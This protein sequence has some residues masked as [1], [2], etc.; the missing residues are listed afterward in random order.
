MIF[1]YAKMPHLDELVQRIQ[2]LE[3][4][5]TEDELRPPGNTDEYF[6]R[7]KGTLLRYS[8]AKDLKTAILEWD[9]LEGRDWLVYSPGS[10]CEL[11]GK[12]PISWLF[13]I[14]NKVTKKTLILGKECIRNFTHIRVQRYTGPMD[15]I[16]RRQIRDLERGKN[17]SMEPV[18][19]I[20]ALHEAISDLV[21][22]ATGQGDFDVNKHKLAL[23]DA[24]LVAV[25]LGVR[26]QNFKF[27]DK[28]LQAAVQIQGFVS[29]TVKINVHQHTM[30]VSHLAAGIATRPK[31]SLQVKIEQL[32]T[33]RSLLGQL[34]QGQS[35]H[36]TLVSIWKDIAD[37]AGDQAKVVSEQCDE[38][39]TALSKRYAPY[40]EML[41]SYQYL[42]FVLTNGLNRCRFEY[43]QKAKSY[44]AK[45]TSQGYLDSL[46]REIPG[47]LDSVVGVELFNPRILQDNPHPQVRA[48][49]H[50]VEFLDAVQ[51]GAWQKSIGT[52]ESVFK[53]Q[54]TDRVGVKAALLHCA[55]DSLIFPDDSGI[56]AIEDF[57]DAITMKSP[58][59]VEVVQQEVDDL[60]KT[61]FEGLRVHEKMSE[62]LGF[63]VR[64]TFQAF[65]ARVP[66]ELHL[67]KKVILAWQKGQQLDGSDIQ[68]LL[69]RR[70]QGA[71]PK[72]TAWDDLRE[73]LMASVGKFVKEAWRFNLWNPETGFAPLFNYGR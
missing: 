51:A 33:F 64:A 24:H 25:N 3:D 53:V 8:F 65:D 2:A 1:V 47:G 58:K 27:V 42:E 60:K 38:A 43:D 49:A 19:Q 5:P 59:V 66:T 40:L 30:L 32:K 13:K 18:D 14:H 52:V 72:V 15:L 4:L 56:G 67:C 11:C 31:I 10:H 23:R 16:L 57:D 54:V 12:V 36:T 73:V 41:R 21:R 44:K 37:F 29:R 35:P 63:D 70:N 20:M 46:K 39:K 61:R 6:E 71:K 7:I 62:D 9:R 48:A 28:A 22:T 45:V 26:T 34:F 55:E 50:L 17:T 69:T 68:K